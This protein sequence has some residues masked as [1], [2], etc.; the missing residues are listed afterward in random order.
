MKHW[1]ALWFC[2]LLA[3]SSY[4]QREAQSWYFGNNAGISF[5]AGAPRAVTDGARVGY[6][7]AATVSDAAGNLL[8][9]TNSVDIWDRNHHL[10]TNG[11]NI[12]GHES[13]AQGAVIVRHPGNSSQYFVFVIDGCDN[14]LLGGL[15]YSTVDMSGPNKLGEVVARGTQ[16]LPLPVAEKVTAIRHA[17]GRDTWVVVHGWETD[18]F[19][20]YLVSVSGVAAAPVTTSIGSVH[21]GGSGAFANANAVGYMKASADGSRLAVARRDSNFELFDFDNATGQLSNYVL[22]PKF[23]R[24]YGVEFSPDGNQLYCSTL[25]DRHIYQFNLLAKTPAAIAASATIVGSS[26]AY[27]GALQAG[28]D[29]KIYAALYNSTF[30]GVIEQPD[31]AGPAC[32]YRDE[33][34]PLHGRM[35]QLGLPNFPNSFPAREWTGAVSASY[36]DPANWRDAVVPTANEDVIIPATALRMPILTTSTAARNLTVEAGASLTNNG[37]LT[38]AGDLI[39]RGSFGSLGT[40][41]S[42][43]D[44]PHRFGG[45]LLKLANLTIG[46][47]A[48]VQLTG[49]VRI[50]QVLTLDGNLTTNGHPLTLVADAAGTA[51]VVNERGLVTGPVMVQHY[52]PLAPGGRGRHHLATPV[53]QLTLASLAAADFTPVTA[54]GPAPTSANV[55]A[56]NGSLAAAD[57]GPAAFRAGWISPGNAASPLISGT[58]Y[59]VQDAP[60]TLSFVGELST[61]TYTA[62]GL[63]RTG[64]PQSG[65]W[66]LGNPYPSPIL[67]DK[68]LPGAAGLDGAV[69]VLQSAGA[70]AGRYASFVRGVSVNGGSNTI[71]MGQAFFVRTSRPG[72]AASLTFTNAARQ[73]TYAGAGAAPETRSLLQLELRGGNGGSQAAV[74]FEPGATAGF[75]PAF[76]AYQLTEADPLQLAIPAG[77]EQL[78]IQGLPLPSLAPVPVPL[79]VQVPQAG[80]YTLRVTQLLNLPAGAAAYLL[81]AATGRRIDLRQQPAYIF[82]TDANPTATRFS[83]LFTPPPALTAQNS[84]L[85]KPTGE[86]AW[87]QLPADLVKKAVGVEFYNLVDETVRQYTLSPRATAA[88]ELSLAGLVECLYVVQVLGTLG[89]MNRRLRTG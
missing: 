11:L 88:L 34:L 14:H 49:P 65:W 67:W 58:G 3:T 39:N 78:T 32:S 42:T 85:P 66:L 33:G 69:Y 68:T 41:T 55:F 79:F 13:A 56:Y 51:L 21:K 1:Y 28:P 20:A 31:V 43:G 16:L 64:A 59:S 8:F 6:E 81:D 17:N 50:R 4:A 75:D 87:L 61:G 5:A 63:T 36:A 27:I 45:N 44:G 35:S 38:L 10:M 72:T 15:K 53:Q 9:Y 24:S 76:D 80:R 77:L 19:Y 25:N 37:T 7:A 60:Q 82:T 54:A 22:L 86:Q 47:E 30:L 29:G 89:A 70:Y 46:Y 26:W 2:L 18:I 57:S 40:L 83:L 48:D 52:R 71:P 73:T 23:Y 74:Y 62:A 84:R 12:G